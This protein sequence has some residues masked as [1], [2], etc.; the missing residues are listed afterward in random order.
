M[1]DDVAEQSTATVWSS[2]LKTI[3]YS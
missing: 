1:S 2:K 3:L